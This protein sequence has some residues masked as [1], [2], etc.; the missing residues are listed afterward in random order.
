MECRYGRAV[1]PAEVVY[2]PAV[3]AGAAVPA[4]LAAVMA[5]GALVARRCLAV[6]MAAE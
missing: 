2:Y 5:R 6:V 3:A 4:A 1:L